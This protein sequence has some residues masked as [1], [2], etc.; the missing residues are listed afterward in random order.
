MKPPAHFE[1]SS[2]CWS[3]TLLW[4]IS[5]SLAESPVCLRRIVSKF[6]CCLPVVRELQAVVREN[7]KT[8][9]SALRARFTIAPSRVILNE[10]TS[11]LD[12]VSEPKLRQALRS[13]AG[14]LT[15][16]VAAHRLSAVA[17]CD[18]LIGLR[19]EPCSSRGGYKVN[20]TMFR[21]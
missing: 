17:E 3:D 15:M 11:A 10:A 16:V 14:K 12:V 2:P 5:G 7:Q 4:L 13:L 6:Y 9:A 18:Q 19:N 1:M 8:T 21:C 20:A